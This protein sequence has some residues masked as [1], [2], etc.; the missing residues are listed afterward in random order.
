MFI[1]YEMSPFFTGKFMLKSCPPRH[2]P[3]ARIKIVL[4]IVLKN[5]GTSPLGPKY[6]LTQRPNEDLVIYKCR[7]T[8]D[9][10][11]IDRFNVLLSFIP[12]ML[13]LVDI[14]LILW[15]EKLKCI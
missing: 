15:C 12:I 6:R 2:F 10:R 8:N 7:A 5:T 13:V 11:I 14:H 1:F 4:R 3:E 9:T